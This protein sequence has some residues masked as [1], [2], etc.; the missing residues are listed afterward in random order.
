MFTRALHKTRVLHKYYTSVSKHNIDTI[1]DHVSSC[2]RRN[3]IQHA[4]RFYNEMQ[5][6][7][8]VET[9]TTNQLLHSLV[10]NPN[11]HHETSHFLSQINYDA[12]TYSILITH[13]MNNNEPQK[14]EQALFE[15]LEKGITPLA[16]TLMT[17]FS[18]YTRLGMLDHVLE[19][20]SD[21]KNKYKIDIAEIDDFVTFANVFMR[22]LIR[23]ERIKDAEHIFDILKEHR[24]IMSFNLMINAY[25]N[26]NER[27]KAEKVFV[28]L[29]ESELEPD[30]YTLAFQEIRR[31]EW[32]PSSR[33]T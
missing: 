30:E 6:L 12:V 8:P 20:V 14:A 31:K 13:H 10:Q 25:I 11:M 26:T 24:D 33:L 18:N 23:Q 9:K 32:K 4:L 19:I 17:L 7:H 27:E 28:M 15:M 16:T 5:K 3:D 22:E 1:N 21:L 29:E 2:L